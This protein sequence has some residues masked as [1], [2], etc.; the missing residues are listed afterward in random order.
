[1]DVWLAQLDRFDVS[2]G[3]DLLDA[4]ERQRA[5]RFVRAEDARRFIARRAIAKLIL[6]DYAGRPADEIS[7]DTTCRHCGDDHGKPSLTAHP[8]LDF[9][10]TSRDDVLLLAVALDRRVGIDIEGVDESSSDWRDVAEEALGDR[11]L[12]AL[13]A[14]PES[15]QRRAALRAWSAKE[16]L[17]K[18]VGL[19]LAW[20]LKSLEVTVA[21]STAAPR[22]VGGMPPSSG[23]HWSL[24]EVSA[25][26]SHVAMLAVSGP[27]PDVVER[28]FEA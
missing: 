10:W 7:F 5:A 23:E 13:A 11:E 28:P 20:D 24:R 27:P 21:P 26:P 6:S 9:S 12:A 3:K 17:L 18:A 25:G 4:T 2:V 16:A 14:M 15:D 22:L 8:R 1:M 19:G